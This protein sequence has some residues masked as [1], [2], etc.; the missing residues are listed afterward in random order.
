VTTKDGRDSLEKR[1]DA[2]LSS[3][4]MPERDAADWE[5]MAENIEARTTAVGASRASTGT[6]L[7]APF[8]P[9]A[10]DQTLAGQVASTSSALNVAPTSGIPSADPK[11]PTGERR[12]SQAPMERERDR[13][14]LKDLA[15]LASAPS[16]T[17]T[18]PPSKAAPLQGPTSTRASSPGPTSSPSIPASQA[19]SPLATTVRKS[20]PGDS[21]IVDLKMM[22]SL[23]PHAAERAKDTKL[24]SAELFDDEPGADNED[25]VSAKSAPPPSSKQAAAAASPA[26]VKTKAPES[27]KSGAASAPSSGRLATVPAS[28]SSGTLASGPAAAKATPIP[29]PRDEESKKGGMIWAGVVA[30]VAVAAAAV[31]MLRS[32]PSAPASIAVAPQPPAQTTANA[33]PKASPPAA[34]P[35]AAADTT[36][37]ADPAPPTDQGVEPSSLPPSAASRPAHAGSGGAVAQAARP[38]EPGPQKSVSVT[39]KPPNPALIAKNIPTN[40]SQAGSFDNALRQ[41]AGPTDTPTSG[42]AAPASG[43]QFDPGSVPQKPSAGA[44]AGGIGNVMGEARACLGLDDPVSYASITFESGGSVSGVAVSG[45]AAGKPAEA[46]IKAALGKAK[47]PPFAQPSY[48]QKVTVRPNS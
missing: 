24:A 12:M 38:V 10:R 1:I 14:S 43:P 46:C 22:A 11:P 6:L 33:A 42:G 4:P 31:F 37:P 16:L 15:K 7:D 5:T 18:P 13:R 25:A 3:W 28:P 39:G 41:A 34:A 8:P 27:S 48:T 36:T 26:S 32:Q 44:I 19:V 29:R 21:G 45:F 17:P 9:D 47:V 40:P 30:V 35:V 20:D 23:D 2:A